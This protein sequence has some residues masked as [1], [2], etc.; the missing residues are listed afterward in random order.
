MTSKA[1]KIT[2]KAQ[3]AKATP[4]AKAAP[5]PLTKAEIARREKAGEKVWRLR[6]GSAAYATRLERRA[7]RAARK[8]AS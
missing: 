1:R 8:E 4:K 7:A 6:D 3:P 5:K 2:D